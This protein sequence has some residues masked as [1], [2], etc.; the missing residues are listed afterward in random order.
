MSKPRPEGYVKISPRRE[1][2][3]NREASQYTIPGDKIV[4]KA[5]KIEENLAQ[6]ARR[7]C[8]DR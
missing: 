1:V 7:L 5:L 3:P 8:A 4:H 6:A 2:V